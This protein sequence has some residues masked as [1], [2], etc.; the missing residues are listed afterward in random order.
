[1][2]TIERKNKWEVNFEIWLTARILRKE[3]EKRG[4]RKNHTRVKPPQIGLHASH[5]QLHCHMMFGQHNNWIFLVVRRRRM[6]CSKVAGGFHFVGL[7]IA[8]TSYFLFFIIIFL[9]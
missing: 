9:S 3:K 8:C 2:I 5:H 1:M 6:H 4:R 7:C